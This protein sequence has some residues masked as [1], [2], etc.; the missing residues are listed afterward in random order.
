MRDVCD[1]HDMESAIPSILEDIGWVQS[2][3]VVFAAE[4]RISL[5]VALL[6]GSHPPL[7]ICGRMGMQKTRSILIRGAKRKEMAIRPCLVHSPCE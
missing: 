6:L 7:G 3:P 4:C 2:E 1:G 5:M